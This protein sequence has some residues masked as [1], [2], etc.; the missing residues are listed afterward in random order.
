MIDQ[1]LGRPNR[2]AAPPRHHAGLADAVDPFVGPQAHQQIVR[3]QVLA[4]RRPIWS[5]VA[6]GFALMKP[7]IAAPFLLWAVFARRPKVI[8]IALS[9]S[10][11]GLLIYC[12]RS[13]ATPIAVVSGYADVLRRFY[14]DGSIGLVGLAQLRPLFALYFD[15]KSAA[16]AAWTVAAV[17]L[18]GLCVMGW[19]EGRDKHVGFAAPALASIWCVMTF[20]QLTYG[21]IV[22]LPAANDKLAL[23][24]RH[25]ELI[26]REAGD[27]QGNSQP[28]RLPVP[29]RDPLDI[30][31]RIPLGRF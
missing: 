31:R 26:A 24:H 25:V 20:Y 3:D 29:A 15:E 11:G 14:V 12:L 2:L 22:L 1:R 8:A 28:F 17:M 4:E 23:F 21:F 16:V 30:V 10:A 27:R 6:L 7:Q 18:V 9:I 19:Q 5:G 13:T